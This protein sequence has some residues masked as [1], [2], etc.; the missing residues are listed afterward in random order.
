MLAKSDGV[1]L[2]DADHAVERVRGEE[3]R[4]QAVALE[5]HLLDDLLLDSAVFV[6]TV[7]DGVGQF[8][9][10]LLVK[11]PRF[12]FVFEKQENRTSPRFERLPHFGNVAQRVVGRLLSYADESYDE[13][14]PACL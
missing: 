10:L 9:E 2:R 12:L 6:D 1:T 13:V 3:N 7:D 14:A 11:F 4:Q 5:F 8:A